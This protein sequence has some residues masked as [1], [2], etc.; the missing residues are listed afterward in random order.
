MND[1]PVKE[2]Q[3]ANENNVIPIA[4]E[5]MPDSILVAKGKWKVFKGVVKEQHD[6][7][8]I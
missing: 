2:K 1:V 4:V 6:R 8:Q 7:N 3:Q 5:V